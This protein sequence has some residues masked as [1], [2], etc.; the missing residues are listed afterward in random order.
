MAQS[1]KP[2]CPRTP[3]PVAEVAAYAIGLASAPV[4]S[5]TAAPSIPPHEQRHSQLATEYVDAHTNRLSDDSF[6]DDWFG[7]T[8]TAYGRYLR[9][10]DVKPQHIV[11]CVR[12]IIDDPRLQFPG[13]GRSIVE[14][15]VSWAIKGYYES[16][17]SRPVGL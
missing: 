7:G 17:G 8:M 4:D 15:A 6:S 14:K 5:T 12:A 2:K 1:A 10:N 9:V 3:T 16:D 13:K 11:I